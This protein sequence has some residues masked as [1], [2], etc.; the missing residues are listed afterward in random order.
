[1]GEH[2]IVENAV[3]QNVMITSAAIQTTL[4]NQYQ[5]N[6]PAASSGG[7]YWINKTL[8]FVASDGEDNPKRF[9]STIYLLDIQDPPP[10]SP[11]TDKKVF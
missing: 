11:R 10:Y 2:G 9:N 5:M 4:I 3:F 7:S 8:F 1:L 6:L